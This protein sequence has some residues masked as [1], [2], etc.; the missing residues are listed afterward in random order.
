M[1]VSIVVAIASLL[2]S[3]CAS[4]Q[5]QTPTREIT[6]TIVAGGEGR[7]EV[8]PDKAT[9]MLGVQTRAK[10]SAAAASTNADRMT[11]IRAALT[12][13]GIP[14]RD[15][16]TANYSLHFEHGRTANDTQYVA[17]NMVTVVTRNLG[18]V[19]RIID[20]GLGA[21]ANNINSLQ[22]DLHDR[23][24]AQ[25]GALTDAVT[26]AR[27][28]AEAMATA[29]GGRLGDLIELTTQP[30]QITPFAMDGA[31][32]RMAEMAQSSA[33]TPVS[34]GAVMIYASVTGRWRFIPGR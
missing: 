1:R 34:P 6:A 15:I 25:N 30:G 5:T 12:R 13:M 19:G 2:A 28:Q 31:R 27:Q 7:R 9:I 32:F 10:T 18:Q 23:T 22:Y 29:A 14:E 20:A 26:N 21:G 8:A 4:A 16:S 24:A 3:G 17:N 11:A 33:P